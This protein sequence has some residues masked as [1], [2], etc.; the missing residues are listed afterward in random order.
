MLQAVVAD[1][2]GE[3]PGCERDARGVRAAIIPGRRRWYLQ[4]QTDY[5][6]IRAGGLK[7]ARPGAEIQYA[8]AWRH[9]PDKIDH[10]TEYPSTECGNTPG[11]RRP[12]CS[13]R[14]RDLR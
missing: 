5:Y 11:P 6:D 2:C 8:S 1:H 3:T 14:P 10:P 12:S 4:I 9:P 7:A 13:S